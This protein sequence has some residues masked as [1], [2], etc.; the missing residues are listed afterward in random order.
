[1]LA[2]KVKHILIRSVKERRGEGAGEGGGGAGGGGGTKNY[3]KFYGWGW[4]GGGGGGVGG[5]RGKR[6]KGTE[7]DNGNEGGVYLR[8][9]SGLRLARCR[10]RGRSGC[11]LASPAFACLCRR[12]RKLP[13]RL[14]CPLRT[15]LHRKLPCRRDRV[16][17]RC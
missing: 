1:M 17:F 3:R 2:K 13:A 6:K 14:C 4:V 12:A 9:L 8:G 10:C 16:S 7:K 11:G 5:E 15:L